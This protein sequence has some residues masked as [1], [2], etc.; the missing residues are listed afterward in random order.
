M[1]NKENFYLFR[2][3]VVYPAQRGLFDT[4]SDEESPKILKEAISSN[5]TTETKQGK[6][7]VIGSVEE[8][9]DQAITFKLGRKVLKLT[10]KFNE[11]NKTFQDYPEEEYPNT[12]IFLHLG[13]QVCAIAQNSKLGVKPY[14]IA[15]RMTQVLGYAD[16][17]VRSQLR[18][19]AQPLYDPEDFIE[20]LRNAYAIQRFVMEFSRPNPVDEEDLIQRPLQ[21]YLQRADGQKGKVEFSGNAM[22][23]EP[24]AKL[25][26][27]AAASGDNT[28]ALIRE[29]AGDKL[30]PK[31]LQNNPLVISEATP[32]EPSE[33]LSFIQKIV[34]SYQRI[35]NDDGKET[36]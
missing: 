16:I 3:K 18:F 34:Q 31:S 23:V 24:L 13:L 12:Q 32:N 11:E 33:R 29:N 6:T 26:H 15:D 5:P 10:P 22:Q 17:A 4:H 1:E 19:N 21:Q 7:W 14:N 2:L 27:A 30:K 28:K 25:A 35:R 20:A 8:I 36:S 9:G